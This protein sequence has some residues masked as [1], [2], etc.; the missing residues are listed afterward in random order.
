MRAI[1]RNPN[2]PPC[3]ADQPPRQDWGDFMLTSCHGLVSDSLRAEQHRLCCYCESSVSGFEGHI[4]HMQPRSVN[5]AATYN[6]ANLAISC[7]GGTIEHCG[8]FKDDRKRNPSYRY[9]AAKFCVPHD[10]ATARLFC[11]LTNG[12]VVPAPGLNAQDREK[13]DY[14]IGYLGLRCVRLEGRRKG[15][16]RNLQ[17]TLG[18]TPDTEVVAWAVSYYLEPGDSGDLQPFHSLSKTVLGQ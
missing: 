3:L 2:P 14:M 8:R 9:D 10:P 16:A 7:D 15:H 12:D 5:E 4:E 1:T 11:Y 17:K 6:Y 18:K 13:A